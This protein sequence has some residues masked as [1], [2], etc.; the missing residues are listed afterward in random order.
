[1]FLTIDITNLEHSLLISCA[2]LG[3][4]LPLQHKEDCYVSAKY[5]S[6]NFVVSLYKQ[7]QLTNTFINTKLTEIVELI[8]K[9]LEKHD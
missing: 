1:M 9:E 8:M 7:N 6:P 3:Y 2:H 5:I 4:K